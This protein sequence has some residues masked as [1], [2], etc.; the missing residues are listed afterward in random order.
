M[1]Q[2]P[3]ENVGEHSTYSNIRIRDEAQ[4]RLDDNINQI[5]GQKEDPRQLKEAIASR[6]QLKKKEVMSQDWGPDR[7]KTALSGAIASGNGWAFIQL[8]DNG[9]NVNG[10]DDSSSRAYGSPLRAAARVGDLEALRLLICEGADI[11]VGGLESAA[12]GNHGAS[13]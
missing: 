4:V 2:E 5:L 6:P 3:A 1:E 11:H 12:V 8:L 9:A 7:K 10:A 13:G